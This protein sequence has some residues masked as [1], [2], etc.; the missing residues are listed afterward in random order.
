MSAETELR[1]L[2]VADSATLALVST[3][4]AAD[5]IEQTAAR[6]FVVY[7]RTATEV[8][9]SLFGEVLATKVVFDVQIWADTRVAAEAVAD[10]VQ[11]ALVADH[12]AIVSR[13]GGYDA[14]LDLE[15]TVITVDWW[16]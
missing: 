11:A 7:T 2:L 12:R 14:D 9:Q 16:D 4:I 10:A 3:R 8:Q 1:A 5:R 13:A 6:P 15:A